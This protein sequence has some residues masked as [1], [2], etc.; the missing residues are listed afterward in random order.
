MEYIHED[1]ETTH[2]IGVITGKEKL[3]LEQEV[4]FFRYDLE[5]L[6]KSVW[7]ELEPDLQSRIPKDV[8]LY[9]KM[10]GEELFK[11]FK[12]LHPERQLDGK[13]IK[14]FL[15]EYYD[16]NSMEFDQEGY[17]ALWKLESENGSPKVRITHR[18]DELAPE[19][20]MFTIERSH[21]VNETNTIYITYGTREHLKDK[22]IS[23]LS[24]AQQYNEKQL[25]TFLQSWKDEV[26]TIKAIFSAP[27]SYRNAYDNTLY[28]TP[29]SVEYN[30][31]KEIQPKL[32]ERFESLRPLHHKNIEEAKESAQK[33]FEEDKKNLYERERNELNELFNAFKKMK[34][35]EMSDVHKYF[36]QRDEVAKKYRKLQNTLEEKHQSLNTP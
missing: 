32:I 14:D 29:G 21:Y 2:N 22:T 5:K 25:Q 36:D 23:E 31:H 33:K 17:E 1:P 11:I 20:K 27:D 28:D 18:I 3:T 26:T 24:H 7:E 13:S 34:S 10:N 16:Q 6:I 4:D 19:K 35:R 12:T 30:A 15:D 9:E 8:S